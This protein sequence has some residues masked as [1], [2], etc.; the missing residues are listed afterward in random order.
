MVVRLNSIE[1]SR[2]HTWFHLFNQLTLVFIWPQCRFIYLTAM[3]ATPAHILLSYSFRNTSQRWWKISVQ[4]ILLLKKL[5]S[6]FKIPPVELLHVLDGV[7]AVHAGTF[8]CMVGPLPCGGAIHMVN[9]EDTAMTVY[10]GF[11][12]WAHRER[13]RQNRVRAMK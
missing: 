9:I 5:L 8:C 1:K 12:V 4:K 11:P 7:G 6:H 10:P 13:D 2:S 3:K